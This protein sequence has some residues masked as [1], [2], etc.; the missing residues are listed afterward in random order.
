MVQVTT[1][2]DLLR[3]A[4]QGDR[5]A[6]TA[7]VDRFL[8]LVYSVIG[9][10]R[11]QPSD[12]QDVSQAVWLHLLENLSSIRQ[13]AAL[14]GWLASTTRNEALRLFRARKRTALVDPGD[15]W[16]LNLDD[17]TAID[18]LLLVAERHQALRDALEELPP[19]NRQL[20]LLLATDP[21]TPYEQI[22]QILN[23][24]LGSVGP[25][26]IRCLKRLRAAAPIQALVDDHEAVL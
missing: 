22:S 7:L 8:P 17:D 9:G 16:L 5:R 1:T 24:P 14:P 18:H 13:P 21:P 12:A 4:A 10:F 3:D 25:T 23:I 26:R 6:W 11:L 15:D 20:L 2:E 19:T